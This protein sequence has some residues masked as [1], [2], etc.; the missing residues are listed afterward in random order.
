MPSPGRFISL[1]NPKPLPP[2]SHLFSSPSPSLS[3]PPSSA[4][5]SPSSLSPP[6]L[7]SIVDDLFQEAN[8][9]ALVQKFKSSSQCHRFRSKHRIYSVTVRRLASANLHDSIADI[10]NH[11]KQFPEISTEGFAVRLISLYG[12]SHMFDHA[13]NLFDELPQLN[14]PRTVKSFNALLT[15]ALNS[16]LFHKVT[17]L[18][19]TLPPEISVKPDVFSYNILIQAF[20]KMGSFGSAVSVLDMMEMNG[21]KPDLVT[22]NS[23]LNGFYTGSQFSD[24]EKIWTK[25]EEYN[26]VPNIISYNE[27]LR[28]LVLEGKT[29]EAVKLV[30]ELG[31]RGLKPSIFSFNSLIKGYC[32][33]GNLEEAKRIFSELVNNDCVPNRWTFEILIPRVCEKGDLNWAV[34]VCKEGM[35]RRR[36]VDVGVIQVVVDALVRESRVEDAKKLVEFGVSTGYAAWSGLKLPSGDE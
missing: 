9:Q 22:F 20:C 35:H 33:D 5:P 6:P 34:K 18:F 26:C 21:V 36:S 2:L 15:A 12:Q 8:L 3:S 13:R 30:G 14:C 27:R 28:G 4:S 32:N 17:E 23:L 25:M 16:K 29:E 24:A 19:D 1:K 31:S 7:K 10:L 11:Q